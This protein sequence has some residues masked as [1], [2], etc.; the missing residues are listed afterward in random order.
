MPEQPKVIRKRI[1]SVSSTKKITR[2]MEMVATAKLKS[3]QQRV[4]S[5]GPYLESLRQLMAEIGASGVDVSKWPHFEVRP[6]NRTLLFVIT[7]NRGLCGSFNTNLVRLARD[8]YREKVAEGHDVRLFVAGKKGNSALR[9]QGYEPERVYIDQL[10]DRP[11]P[12]DA[13]YFINELMAPFLENEVDEVLVVYPH[14][15]SLG[16]Q[17][18]TLLRL[19]PIAPEGITASSGPAPLF[20]PSAELILDKLLPLYGR[21]IMYSVLAEAVASE[22]VARRIAMK[23]ASDNASDMVNLLTRQY[24]RAR[25]ALI[26]KEIA[27][28]L[29]GSEALKE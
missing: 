11:T 1:K 24:N 26:T 14:W 12:D 6:G 10:S 15:E 17:P 13:E 3:A 9:F 21:Q 29:G 18:A 25:Q 19:L 27:E 20:E 16:R 23:L 5:S 28:I 7:A 2:T 4:A 8:T 22:Q